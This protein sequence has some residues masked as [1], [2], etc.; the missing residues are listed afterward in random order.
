MSSAKFVLVIEKDAT[1]QRLLD[2]EFCTQFYPC[3]II[4]VGIT[5]AGYILGTQPEWDAP[6]LHGTINMHSLI[7]LDQGE[8]VKLQTY[9]HL[10]LGSNQPSGCETEMTTYCTTVPLLTWYPDVIIFMKEKPE[11]HFFLLLLIQDSFPLA[12]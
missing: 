6:S 9:S 4:T 7:R 5:A 10:S 12:E 8:H 2:D 3:I 1:F 11:C